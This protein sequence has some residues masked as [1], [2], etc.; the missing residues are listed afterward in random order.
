MRQAIGTLLLAVVGIGCAGTQPRS[1]SITQF[2]GDPAPGCVSLGEVT[3]EDYAET[4]SR[5]AARERA[6]RE[7]ARLGATHVRV[8]P[9]KTGLLL[10]HTETW[11]GVAFRCT[12]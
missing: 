6:W 11:T 3:A 1:Q 4:P 5:D 9:D 2:T 10:A 7:A 8:V 12:Q